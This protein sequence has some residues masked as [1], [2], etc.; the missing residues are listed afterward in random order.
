[1]LKLKSKISKSLAVGI[2]L[3]TILAGCS[4]NSESTS[5]SESNSNKPVTLTML[6]GETQNTPGFQAVVKKLRKKYNIKTEVE[7]H[8]GGPE[9]ENI[10]KTRLATGEMADLTIFNSGSLLKKR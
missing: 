10:M 6:L 8:P 2:A 7:V 5:G 1:M 3:S 9:G 4:G